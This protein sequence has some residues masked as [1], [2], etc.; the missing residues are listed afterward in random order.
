MHLSDDWYLNLAD[1]QARPPTDQPWHAL[2]RAARASGDEA[3]ARHAAA[4]R[5]PG[6][7]IANEREGLGRLLRALVD[8][9]WAQATAESSPLPRDVWLQSIQLLVARPTEGSAHGLTLAVKGGHND[10]HHNHNDVGQV[11]IAVHGIPVVVDA[12]RPT[13][14]AQTFGPDR[15]QIPTMHSDWH[16][17]PQIRG[18]AQHH[19]RQYAARHVEPTI[20]EDGAGLKLDLAAAYPGHSQETWLRTA[21]LDRWAE[22]VV[23]NDEWNLTPGPQHSLVRYLLAGDVQLAPG[24]ATIGDLALSWDPAVPATLDVLP[25]EDPMLCDVWGDHL[26]RLSLDVGPESQGTLSV[27]ARLVPAALR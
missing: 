9:D 4:H 3:A 6:T 13:Y 18:T 27:I 10:E 11:V 15:Y 22:I 19:G 7:P 16:S 8:Q 17:V 20:V 23:I 25:L 12:G 21:Y 14:T 26:T 5:I 1:G 2:H 24:Q